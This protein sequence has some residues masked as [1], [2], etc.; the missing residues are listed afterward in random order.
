MR[1]LRKKHIITVAIDLDGVVVDLV[2]AISPMLSLECN[3]QI[4][5]NDIT[6]YDMGNHCVFRRRCLTFGIMYTK[7]TLWQSLRQLQMLWKALR[8]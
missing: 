2:S 3:R 6:S 8:N 4:Y 1:R 5:E 7:I